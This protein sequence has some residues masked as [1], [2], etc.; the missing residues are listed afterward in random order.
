MTISSV[1]PTARGSPATI[2]A[3]MIIVMPL[4]TPRSVICSPSHITN[5]VPVAIE[6]VATN[7]NWK[8]GFETRCPPEFWIARAAPK[9]WKA[10]RHTVP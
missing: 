4:P 8:P 1:L 7:K 3:T 10:A 5:M 6:T 9:P 2:P